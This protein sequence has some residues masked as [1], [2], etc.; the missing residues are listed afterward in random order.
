MT[1]MMKMMRR[2]EETIR[3]RR[4]RARVVREKNMEEKGEASERRAVL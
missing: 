2:R 3:K 1:A 4:D